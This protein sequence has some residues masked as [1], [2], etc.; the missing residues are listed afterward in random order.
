MK[1]QDPKGFVGNAE[2]VVVRDG[3]TRM[4]RHERLERWADALAA[5]GGA[6]NALR[7]IEYL[8]PA[9]RR[10]Y[11]GENSPLTIAYRDPILRAEGLKS[12]TL[13]DVMDFFELNEIDVH[14]LLCD[15]HY[16]GT[17]TGAGLAARLRGYVRRRSRGR[18]GILRSVANLIFGRRSAATG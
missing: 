13:G 10:A 2:A 3:L 16:H 9:E 4:S 7:R 15:C 11:H 17:M 18:D 8:R 6:L 5:H 12:E 1:H 14:G